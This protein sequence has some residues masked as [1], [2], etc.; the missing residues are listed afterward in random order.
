MRY[1]REMRALL[2]DIPVTWRQVASL[3]AAICRWLRRAL[4]W[5]AITAGDSD[6]SGC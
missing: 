4:G 6:G 5:P 1:E 2:E 3:A